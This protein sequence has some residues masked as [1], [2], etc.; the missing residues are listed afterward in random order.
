MKYKQILQKIHKKASQN[1]DLKAVGN[2]YTGMLQLPDAFFRLKLPAGKESFSSALKSAY[3]QSGVNWLNNFKQNIKK[4][5]KAYSRI[6]TPQ[7]VSR[8]SRYFNPA[9][10]AN[11]LEIPSRI[12][13]SHIQ[14]PFGKSYVIHAPKQNFQSFIQH[15]KAITGAGS[16]QEYIYKKPSLKASNDPQVKTHYAYNPLDPAL[17]SQL[18]AHQ[19]LHQMAAHRIRQPNKVR[20]ELNNTAVRKDPTKKTNRM[21]DSYIWQ[22]WQAA[23]ANLGAGVGR[24]WL[25]E[26]I[27][28]TPHNYKNIKP[29]NL[30]Y[31]TTQMPN[32]WNVN[33]VEKGK[34]QARDFYNRVKN[35]PGLQQALPLQAN[36]HYGNLKQLQDRKAVIQQEIKK[37][38]TPQTKQELHRILQQL[39]KIEADY[40]NYYLLSNNNK[41]RNNYV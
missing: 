30:K 1:D 14:L 9:F 40:Q 4:Y 41:N 29:E 26:Q 15:R 8:F 35:D 2:Q 19:F 32:F 37:A 6:Y 27:V 17:N 3:G 38:E 34:T 7:S 10:T 24:N 16:N 36:R 28:K 18:K 39:K 11:T 13:S 12:F 23:Q 21:L 5:P 22:P 25:K 33:N 31:I 20:L